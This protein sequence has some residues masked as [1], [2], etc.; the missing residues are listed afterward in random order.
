M[1]LVVRGRDLRRVAWIDAVIF[2]NAPLVPL[3]AIGQIA[4]AGGRDGEMRA[5]R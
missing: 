5:A 2:H 3:L 1:W 4:W